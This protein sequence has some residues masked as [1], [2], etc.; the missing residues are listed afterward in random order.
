MSPYLSALYVG[1]LTTLCSILLLNREYIPFLPSPE[2][3]PQGPVDPPLLRAVAPE[4][5][6]EDRA[7]DLFQAAVYITDML[8]DLSDIDS[9]LLTPFTGFCVFSAATMNIYVASFPRMNLGRSQDAAALANINLQ[10]LEK[11]KSSWKLGIRWVSLTMA[12]RLQN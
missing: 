8:R 3:E 7:R 6:W 12:L 10:Y 4:D 5:W 11:F 2:S 9:S 1:R